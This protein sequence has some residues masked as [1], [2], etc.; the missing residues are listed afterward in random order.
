MQVVDDVVEYLRRRGCGQRDD[1]GIGKLRPQLLQ[2]TVVR[3]KIMSPLADAMRLVNGK[4]AN[5]QR[6]QKI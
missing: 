3:A 1:G 2:T 6:A 4:Q 5:A